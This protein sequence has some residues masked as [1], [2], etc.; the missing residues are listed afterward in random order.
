MDEHRLGL[1]EIEKPLLVKAI[2]RKLDDSLRLL[3][4]GLNWC[5][6]SVL[7]SIKVPKKSSTASDCLAYFLWKT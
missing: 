2:A 3:F 5:I 4:I 7:A 1:G 6:Y